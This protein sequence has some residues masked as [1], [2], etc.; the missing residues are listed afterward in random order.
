[1]KITHLFL[2]VLFLACSTASRLKQSGKS[3][4]FDIKFKH[5][6]WKVINPQQSDYAFAEK[7]NGHILMVN[8]E[9]NNKLSVDLK[10]SSLKTFSNLESYQIIAQGKTFFK[11]ESAYEIYAKAILDKTKVEIFSL[12]TVR[13]NCY[14]DFVYIKSIHSNRDNI[15]EQF[16]TSIHFND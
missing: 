14:Y 10:E 12:S 15:F 13:K 16:L 8:S 6:N 5:P 3:S 2:S 11:K 9:C 7:R 4:S 1:M